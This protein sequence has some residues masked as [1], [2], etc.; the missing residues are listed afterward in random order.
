MPKIRY[1]LVSV[2]LLLT[3]AVL[4]VACT[5][6]SSNVSTGNPNY[7]KNYQTTS[8]SRQTSRS[9][10]EEGFPQETYRPPVTLE[11]VAMSTGEVLVGEQYPIVAVVSNPEN[12][13]LTYKWT[14]EDGTF[15]EVPES[16]RSGLIARIQELE[17]AKG[18]PESEVSAA[19]A[20]S[21]ESGESA[22]ASRESGPGQPG[23]GISFGGPK[24][25]TGA[26]M[27]VVSASE[28]ESQ[29][30]AQP[31]AQPPSPPA[32]APAAGEETEEAE[33]TGEVVS[34]EETTP[35]ENQSEAET[36]DAAGSSVRAS[37]ALTRSAVLGPEN[38]TSTVDPDAESD[39]SGDLS[40][41]ESKAQQEEAP[42]EE[43]ATDAAAGESN[44]EDGATQEPPPEA[45]EPASE[46]PRTDDV[47]AED[48]ATEVD[49]EVESQTEKVAEVK[50]FQPQAGIGRLVEVAEEPDEQGEMVGEET[51]AAAPPLVEFK[52]DK[53]YVLWTA[54]ALGTYTIGLVVLDNKGNELTPKRSFPVTAT[55]PIPTTELVWNTTRKLLEDDYL[56]VEL[57]GHNI[58]VFDKGLFTINFDPSALSF[59]IAEP[60]SFFPQGYRTSVYFAQP[61]GTPGKV[62]IAIAAE[63]VGLPKGDGVIARAIFKVKDNVD[64]PSSLQISEGTSPEARYILNPQQENVLPVAATRPVFAAEWVEPP[65]APQQTRQ[66]PQARQQA[67][68]GPTP[69]TG[70]EQTRPPR[71]T[72]GGTAGPEPQVAPE[73][74]Q[75]HLPAGGSPTQITPEGESPEAYAGP[76]ERGAPS[77]EEEIAQ[78]EQEKIKI[79][80]DPNLT[81]ED[82]QQAIE[83]INAQIADL[84][85]QGTA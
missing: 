42:V 38:E 69:P 41:A 26:S 2:F 5:S 62:T 28:S 60:G 13:D 65:A 12:R 84:Q 39:E 80:N 48:V 72:F 19:S 18:L 49:Q 10:Q 45:E 50:G 1:L 56:V 17:Q 67:A 77:L 70:Q 24:E 54:P 73:E 76:E 59:K 75:Q 81:E 83:G 29:G 23:R 52:T 66:T 27:P 40:A 22:K 79:Q 14:V 58:P 47:G 3:A 25:G 63:E 6:S 15:D 21:A 46:E 71:P 35:A 32:E 57:R 33:Q 68:E 31:A 20:T 4:A 53:P 34:E 11:M 43:A 8:R 37:S 30:P 55:E 7:Q 74:R 9:P 61:P 64:E 16:M 85:S 44:D 36:D 51:E 78:L 82:K